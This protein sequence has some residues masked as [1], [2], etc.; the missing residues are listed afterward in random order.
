M[1]VYLR[2][3][4]KDNKMRFLD[5][6][7]GKRKVRDRTKEVDKNKEQHKHKGPRN[8]AQ[9][10]SDK[11]LETV[12]NNDNA[13]DKQRVIEMLYEIKKWDHTGN[14]FRETLHKLQKE[15]P[16]YRN[17]SDEYEK[18]HPPAKRM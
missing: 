7:L 12:G 8:R 17:I 3:K 10:L 5:Y 4:L 13:I 11:L 16:A 15:Y 6:I 18:A 9:E 1:R 14:K 2:K